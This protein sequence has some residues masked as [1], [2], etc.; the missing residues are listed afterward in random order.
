MAK[1]LLNYG[2]Q[3]EF[4]NAL[5]SNQIEATGLYFITDTQRI[6]KGTNVVAMTSVLYPATMPDASTMTA[7]TCG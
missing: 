5:Q 2:T 7:G 4:N 3:A 6:Y 1:Q